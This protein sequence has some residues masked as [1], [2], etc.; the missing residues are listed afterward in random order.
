MRAHQL[1]KIYEARRRNLILLKENKSANI[2]PKT[3]SEIEGAISEIDGFL[4]ML[5]KME[6]EFKY[7]IQKEKESPYSLKYIFL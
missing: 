7:K 1:I 2:K 5:E 3:V 6:D 4:R